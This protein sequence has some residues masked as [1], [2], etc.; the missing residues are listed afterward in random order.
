MLLEKLFNNL[1]VCSVLIFVKVD[2]VVDYVREQRYNGER[3]SWKPYNTTIYFLSEL[4]SVY[5]FE[6]SLECLS[7]SV[8]RLI[9]VRWF[10]ATEMIF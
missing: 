5:V 8:Y 9:G 2:L 3:S 10:L 1:H 4:F 6:F 7:D